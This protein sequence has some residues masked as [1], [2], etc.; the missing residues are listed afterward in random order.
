MNINQLRYFASVAELQSFTKAAQRHYLSQT[1]ITQQVRAL[2]STLG[3]RLLDRQTRPI[4]LTPA[5]R[6]FLREAKAILARV[7]AAVTRTRETSAGQVGTLRIGYEKGYERSELSDHLREFHRACPNI[8]LTCVRADT[9]RLAAELLAGDLD[10]IF[11][12]DS[13]NLR[14]DPAIGSRLIERSPLMVALYSDHPL[15]VRSALRRQD[16]RGETILYMTPS[17]NGE[18]FR[19]AYFMQLY[20]KAGYQ[21]HILLKSNDVESILMMVATEEGISVVPAYTVKKLSVADHLV[22]L[23]LEGEDEAEEIWMM[24]SE[25][26]ASA[27]L[28]TF[29]A[30]DWAV[31]S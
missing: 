25:A 7:D 19:D 8:L 2:E 4:T 24:W 31:W 17:S 18:S 26:R 12:W 1:A 20:E 13:T 9:D 23:P 15:A 5:G 14:Q 22:F 29:L 11:A 10:V 28:R 3:V 21:P 16:L 6:V 30:R 27:A